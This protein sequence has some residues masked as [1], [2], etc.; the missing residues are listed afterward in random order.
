MFR[1]C[2]EIDISVIVKLELYIGIIRFFVC[3]GQLIKFFS[4]SGDRKIAGLWFARGISTQ[5]GTMVYIYWFSYWEGWGEALP[6][7]ENSPLH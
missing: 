4:T 3:L 5:G 1:G 7:A 2:S 6:P